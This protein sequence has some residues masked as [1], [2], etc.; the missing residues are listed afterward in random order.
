MHCA[1]AIWSKVFRSGASGESPLQLLYL[2]EPDR[3]RALRARL[4]RGVVRSVRTLLLLENWKRDFRASADGER[5]TERQLWNACCTRHYGAGD[6]RDRN[7]SRAFYSGRELVAR[8]R[9][10]IARVEMAK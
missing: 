2:S 9:T 1:S 6:H 4:G 3:E 8:D 5:A 10:S 7:V